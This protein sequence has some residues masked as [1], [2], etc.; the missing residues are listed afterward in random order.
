MEKIFQ[1]PFWLRPLTIDGASGGS[2]GKYVR[3]L[4]APGLAAAGDEPQS[5]DPPPAK[6]SRERMDADPTLGGSEAGAAAAAAEDA[7]GLEQ[8]LATVKLTSAEVEL[9]ASP[10]IG[11]LAGREPRSVKRLVNIY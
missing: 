9:I 4:L 3:Q 7:A 11:R 2:Y 6:P 8:A 1:L 5:A 10:E